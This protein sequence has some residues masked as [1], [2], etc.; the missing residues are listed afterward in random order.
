M[1]I[2]SIIGNMHI[3]NNTYGTKDTKES[4]E[5]ESKE[6]SAANQ[7]TA[8]KKVD[9]KGK[10]IGQPKLSEKAAKYY[11]EL[12]SKYKNMDFILVSKDMK[13]MA[14]ANAGSF[15]NPQKMVVLIDEEKVERMAED[16]KFRK[17]YEGVIASAQ[18][19]LPQL[20]QALGRFSNVKGFGVQ[21]KDNGVTSFFAVMNKS[22]ND[23]AARLEKRR[24]EKKA[25]KKEAEKKVEKKERQERLEEK[26][27][28]LRL[29]AKE[30]EEV[31]S[32]DS[33][34]ELVKMVEDFNYQFVSDTTMT[35]AE[36]GLG[37]VIDFKG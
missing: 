33:V 24:I 11:E 23:Q 20:K 12:K 31:L 8:G 5:A 30:A 15:A 19:Q 22:F 35:E 37:T 25:E 18:K 29:E 6:T 26:R 16:E 3:A 27:E 13:E 4:K 7:T 36:K 1:G 10:T 9:V 2:E 34:E 17:Q 28:E 21:V 14:K 32:A